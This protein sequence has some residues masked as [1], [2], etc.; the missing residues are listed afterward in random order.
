M[1][2]IQIKRNVE[3][4]YKIALCYTYYYWSHKFKII[5]QFFKNAITSIK[6]LKICSSLK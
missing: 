2:Y 4:K 1:F 3:D 5:L 6:L